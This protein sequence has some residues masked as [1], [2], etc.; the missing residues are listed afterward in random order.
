MKV[1]IKITGYIDGKRKSLIRTLEVPE[2][3]ETEQSFCG[4]TWITS[5]SEQQTDWIDDR[6][7]DLVVEY[8]ES[9]WMHPIEGYELIV[10]KTKVDKLQEVMKATELILHDKSDEFK[11]LFIGSL[12]RHWKDIKSLP[13]ESIIKITLDTMTTSFDVTIAHFKDMNDRIAKWKE[14]DSAAIQKELESHQDGES[15]IYGF[16][17]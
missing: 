1:K 4:R 3:Q 11:A 9:R 2:F 12:H 8:A 13:I 15:G 16:K 10:P 5:I 14:D 17:F 6:Y 7:F